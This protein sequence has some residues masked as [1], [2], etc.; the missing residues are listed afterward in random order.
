MGNRI[1]GEAGGGMWGTRK[2]A[3]CSG[4]E[5]AGEVREHV[6][7]CVCVCLVGEIQVNDLFLFIFILNC[8]K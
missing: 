3:T 2:E 6:R 8:I 4:L 7:A 5:R 1:S